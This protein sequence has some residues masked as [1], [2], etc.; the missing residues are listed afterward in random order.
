MLV[1]TRDSE[2]PW[3]WLSARPE[4]ELQ[5]EQHEDRHRASDCGAVDRAILVLALRVP[6]GWH[7]GDVTQADF[8][9]R[10]GADCELRRERSRQHGM[11]EKRISGDPPDQA[12]RRSEFT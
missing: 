4:Q 11:Q 10:V 8:K 2:W 9:S 6:G 1:W 7:A 3:A 5:E 12:A